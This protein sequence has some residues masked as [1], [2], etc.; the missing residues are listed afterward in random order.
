VYTTL[1]VQHLESLNDVVSQ[2]TGVNV[3]ETV[4][5][6]VLERADEIELVDLPPDD[7][8]QRLKE[9]KVYLPE[10]AAAAIE[11]FFRKG[12]LIAL[13]ELAL[14][15]TA[16]RVDEQMR[17]YRQ[18]KGITNIWPASE[19]ILVCV[20]ANPRSIGSFTPP[21][22]LPPVSARMDRRPC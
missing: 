22:G 13:R 20:G 11:N 16:D 15:R 4:P 1:N 7:L 14:R 6:L 17:D 19:R 12:N 9:G 10:Q 21:G 2:I 18:D 8:I 5:D 3:R